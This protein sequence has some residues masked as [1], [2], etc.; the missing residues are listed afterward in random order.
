MT[1]PH[2]ERRRV[3][4]KEEGRRRGEEREESS[5][6]RGD[7]PSDPRRRADDPTDRRRGEDPS[8]PRRRVD[9]REEGRRRQTTRLRSV[10]SLVNDEVQNVSTNQFVLKNTLSNICRIFVSYSKVILSGAG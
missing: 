5:R 3:E 10:D 4:E 6:R 9:E 8:D 2:R 1:S 7:D